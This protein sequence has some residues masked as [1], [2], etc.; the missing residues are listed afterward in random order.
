MEE[1]EGGGLPLAPEPGTV[2]CALDDIPDGGAREWTRGEGPDAYR[3]LLLRLDDEVFA[4]LNCCPH[5]SLPLNYEPQVFHVFDREYLMCAHHTALF[6]IRNGVC[7]DGP[8]AGARL[9]SVPVAVAD[10]QVRIASAQNAGSQ[11]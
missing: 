5:F 6:H 1:S 9:R 4:Y 3:L 2:I 8:C 7:F 10:R 11:E